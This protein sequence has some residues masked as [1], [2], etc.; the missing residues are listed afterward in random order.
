M[1][2]VKQTL[3]MPH[4]PSLFLSNIQTVHENRFIE[5]SCDKTHYNTFQNFNVLDL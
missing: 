3:S 2:H 5:F 4:G 1:Y